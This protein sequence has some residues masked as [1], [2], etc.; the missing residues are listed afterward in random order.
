M[1]DILMLQEQKAI[2]GSGRF[3]DLPK[4]IVSSIAG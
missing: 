1:L 3:F 4:M 2:I